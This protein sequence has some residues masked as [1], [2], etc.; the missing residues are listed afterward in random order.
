[1]SDVL[2]I[3]DVWSAPLSLFLILLLAA[4][5]FQKYQD[6]EI[7]PYFFAG[8]CMKLLGGLLHFAYH[9]FVYQGG[10]TFLYYFFSRLWIDS[11]FEY[12]GA[13][14]WS[15]V[16]TPDAYD[17][18]VYENLSFVWYRSGSERQL[19]KVT[20]PL[21]LLT[22]ESFLAIGLWLSFFAYWGLWRIFK[23]I[24]QLYPLLKNSA[25]FAVLFL[26]SVVFWSSS[27]SKD[28]VTIGCLG[29]SIYALYQIFIAAKN[30]RPALMQG[31]ILLPALY[32]LSALKGYITLAIVPAF[33]LWLIRVYAQK[34]TNPGVR[35]II[36]PAVLVIGALL[37]VV[38]LRLGAQ[39]EAFREFA[40]SA[41]VN[42][43]YV[44]YE[45]LSDP[46]RAG[47]AYDL[48]LAAPTWT[49]VLRALPKAVNV[50]LFRPY[51][52]EARGFASLLAALESLVAVLIMIFVI[53]QSG[54]KGIFR[55]LREE[56]FLVFCLTF[57]L[58]FG[59]AVGLTSGNFGTLMR[60]K[61]PCMP[62]FFF[63][64]AYWLDQVLKSR[65]KAVS[66]ASTE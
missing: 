51:L 58:I 38:G 28:A 42:K 60:Y 33:G 50:A 53:T 10:D 46:N 55:S 26:P 31:L 19:L 43:I 52:W 16:Q 47:S 61:I 5:K 24:V 21:A 1:M 64:L 34:I 39:T 20:G 57:T 22:F 59:A 11:L 45:Y 40:T 12:P 54:I 18:Q 30:T 41:V 62:F 65:K 13:T 17:F 25:A 27:I 63:L 23:M 32:L 44:Q 9:R 14:L 37:L 7:A 56:P 36:T 49:G 4:W 15:L 2:G 66:Y 6:T 3:Q 8:L 29:V 48:G 35:L